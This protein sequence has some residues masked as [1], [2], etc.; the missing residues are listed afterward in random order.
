MGKADNMTV[1]EMP[2]YIVFRIII[3]TSANNNILEPVNIGCLSPQSENLT[4]LLTKKKWLF[5]HGECLAYQHGQWSLCVCMGFFFCIPFSHYALFV[6]AHVSYY[7]ISQYYWHDSSM[8]KSSAEFNLAAKHA[9]IQPV[10]HRPG[11]F[12]ITWNYAT[13][14]SWGHTLCT[15]A[16]L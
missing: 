7:Y 11:S 12:K 9:I 5:C 1:W 10:G 16:Q 8:I 15:G 14:S 4:K 3:I 6:L 13:A 2:N